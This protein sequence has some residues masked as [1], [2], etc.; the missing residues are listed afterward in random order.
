ML[1]PKYVALNKKFGLENKSKFMLHHKEWVDSKKFYRSS[2]A[3]S[4]IC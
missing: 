4:K 3:N 2:S 1:F